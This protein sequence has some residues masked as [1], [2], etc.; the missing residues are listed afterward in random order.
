METTAPEDIAAFAM[1]ARPVR[2]R[3]HIAQHVAIDSVNDAAAKFP[4]PLQRATRA[5]RTT[6]AL[7]SDGMERDTAPEGCGDPACRATHKGHH[8][9]RHSVAC[10]HYRS[11]ESGEF[12]TGPTA[13]FESSA[14]VLGATSPAP[15][16]RQCPPR[17]TDEHARHANIHRHHSSGF[18]GAHHIAEHLAAAAGH[19]FPSLRVHAAEKP[20]RKGAHEGLQIARHLTPLTPVQAVAE[21]SSY[22][23]VEDPIQRGHPCREEPAHVGSSPNNGSHTLSP[24]ALPQGLR[25]TRQKHGSTH[26]DFSNFRSS[27]G[28]KQ[29]LGHAWTG[30]P[31]E[32]THSSTL[33][34][35]TYA[36]HDHQSGQSAHHSNKQITAAGSDRSS[37]LCNQ[38][39][40]QI[41]SLDST[42]FNA[43]VSEGASRPMTQFEAPAV[44]IKPHAAHSKQA[45]VRQ[46]MAEGGI[47]SKISAIQQRVDEEERKRSGKVEPATNPVT[48]KQIAPKKRVRS[49]P[50]WLKHPSHEAAEDWIHSRLRHVSTQSQHDLWRSHLNANRQLDR[51]KSFV[52]EG[53]NALRSSNRLSAAHEKVWTA[54]QHSSSKAEESN[55]AEDWAELLGIRSNQRSPQ[56]FRQVHS[57]E[58]HRGPVTGS[59]SARQKTPVAVRPQTQALENAV[60]QHTMRGSHHGNRAL[61]EHY[62][63]ETMQ[64]QE[65]LQRLNIEQQLV[66]ET[67]SA[68]R[69]ISNKS[70]A[71]QVPATPL[72]PAHPH[73]VALHQGQGAA[74]DSQVFTEELHREN[75][76]SIVDKPL[77]LEVHRPQPVAPPN[78]ACSWKDRYMSLTTEIR[79]LKAE[80]S[81]THQVE[82]VLQESQESD[83]LGIEGLT[84]VMHLKGKD[85]LVINTDLTQEGDE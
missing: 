28:V 25:R 39:E 12:I 79:H 75:G 11:S 65:E 58:H 82:A 61:Q 32:D 52:R 57:G 46:H 63:E 3:Q 16:Q 44:P 40:H 10:A 23:Y 19:D 83:N 37:A 77:D 45:V 73:Q 43:D 6:R 17:S 41:T 53:G 13:R 33:Y 20:H 62:Q 5:S 7:Q 84:I 22:E 70:T 69:I 24:R 35:K 85:D 31:V 14:E 50:S 42:H 60:A 15:G 18:H 1:S 29:A 34:K 21:V 78:H 55:R 71:S 72:Q 4:R 76:L 54:N 67:Q 81:A 8:P 51:P 80:M 27:Q 49:P 9:Y 48:H 30:E 47:H 36:T 66:R 38:E 26:N 56:G 74:R 64:T 68:Q 2:G 59:D